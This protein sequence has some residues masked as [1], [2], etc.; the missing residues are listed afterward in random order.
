[1]LATND[2]LFVPLLVATGVASSA[3]ILLLIG[4]FVQTRPRHVD[5]G[6]AA[7]LDLEHEPVAPALV[8]LLVNHWQLED[9]ASAATLVDLAA[10]GILKLEDAGDGQQICRL[11]PDA[12]ASQ[13]LPH[14]QCVLD[15][16]SSKASNGTVPL[17]ALNCAPEEVASWRSM[18][19]SEVIAE[20]RRLGL[21]RP[22]FTSAAKAL[23][24]VTALVPAALAYA[25]GAAAPVAAHV[26]ES[27]ARIPNTAI[28]AGAIVLVL[29]IVLIGVLPRTGKVF[30]GERSTTEGIDA[31][32]RWLGFREYLLRDKVFPTLPPTAVVTWNRNLSYG[33]AL[34]AAAATAHALPFGPEPDRQAWSPVTGKWRIVRVSYPRRL[35]WGD[36]PWRSLMRGLVFLGLAAAI[37]YG[38]EAARQHASQL[39]EP[40]ISQ[41]IAI[42]SVVMF[43]FVVPILCI[44]GSAYVLRG[45][46]DLFATSYQDGL[47]VRRRRYRSSRL[48]SSGNATYSY[49]VAVD[50]GSHGRLRAYRVD[51]VSYQRLREGMTVNL[52][53]TRN[54]GHVSQLWV[55]NT[56]DHVAVPIT[57]SSVSPSD[58]ETAAHGT[59]NVVLQKSGVPLPGIT[60]TAGNP[61]IGRTA[62]T[63]QALNPVV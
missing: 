12:D 51:P 59:R 10:R 35:L 40:A 37:V 6:P 57:S 24:V 17:G 7:M 20:A 9:E 62:A 55:H 44:L 28:A 3:W 29:F 2:H 42:A 43:A 1:M 16:V 13:L 5:V 25:A 48:S 18:F 4:W 33:V 61:G 50:D 39:A 31:A 47:V 22:R 15:R 27:H 46:I 14:E 53:V 8:N 11:K 45:A 58:D 30:G 19:V 54:L 26:Q 63:T 34:G 36:S 56:A 60:P 38:Y 41:G 32:K 49:Y 23:L 21:S 52:K